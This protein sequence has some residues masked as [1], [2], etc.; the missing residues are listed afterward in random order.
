M[1]KEIFINQ[2]FCENFLKYWYQ[3]LDEILWTINEF[4]KLYFYF[5]MIVIHLKNDD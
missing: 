3:Y 2:I 1:K 5:K 4:L